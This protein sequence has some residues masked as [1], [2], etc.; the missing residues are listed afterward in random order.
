M[1][2]S[3]NKYRFTAV[4]YEMCQ[5]H[6][7]LCILYISNPKKEKRTILPMSAPPS[8]LLDGNG[9]SLGGLYRKHVSGKKMAAPSPSSW[10]P[11]AENRSCQVG[12]E[13]GE[14]QKARR[15]KVLDEVSCCGI[16]AMD[17]YLRG[18]LNGQKHLMSVFNACN[19]RWWFPVQWFCGFCLLIWGPMTR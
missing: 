11:E 4:I 18:K 17:L 5:Q 19:F 16:F 8:P 7:A 10:W 6:E 14:G 13:E 2:S 3:V 12:R 1:R 9:G 15:V